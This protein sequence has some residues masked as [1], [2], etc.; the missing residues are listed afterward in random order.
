MDPFSKSS[1]WLLFYFINQ[2]AKTKSAEYTVQNVAAK[3]KPFLFLHLHQL[4]M[5]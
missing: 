3:M 4:F 2:T 5:I 1:L